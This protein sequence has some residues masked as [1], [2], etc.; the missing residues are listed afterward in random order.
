[1]K[2]ICFI[3]TGLG[4]GGAERQVCDL[5]DNFSVLGCKIMIIS[6]TDIL[7]VK[8]RTTSIEVVSLGLKKNLTNIL[9]SLLKAR[10]LLTVFKPDIVHSH[11]YH[12]NIF[13]RL[14][15]LIKGMPVLVCTAHNTVE[16]GMLR[17]FMYRVTDRLATINTNVSQDAVDSF[18]QKGAVSSNRMIFMPNGID[19]SRFDFVESYRIERRKEI[20]VSNDELLLLSV[21]RL[22]AAKDYNNLLHAF[23]IFLKDNNAKLAIIGTGELAIDL[24]ALAIELGINS[25]IIWLN[26]RDDVNQWMSAMDVYV[27]SSAW[28][29]MPLVLCEA[30]ASKGCIVTTDCGGTKDLVEH[31]GFV[32]EKQNARHLSL[33]LEKACKLTHG[34]RVVIGERARERV[35]LKYSIDAI[36]KKWLTL[37]SSLS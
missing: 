9:P 7:D 4:V 19:V 2:K 35:R 32:V 18:I 17:M 23:S 33:G 15:R 11:M 36:C 10:K 21:G 25:N 20:N 37:Y 16:G 30:M 3:I 22:T 8:P 26:R 6:L 12:A 13:S 31:V 34:E 1:M 24:K 27:M 29:G 14:L 28:E 5:A